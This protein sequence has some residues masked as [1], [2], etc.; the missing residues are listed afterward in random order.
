MF[1]PFSMVTIFFLKG[2]IIGFII[3]V[4]VGP[5]GVVCARRMLMFGRR[6]GFFSGM[7]SA[8]AD[9]IYGFVAA[10]GL[11]LVSD[12]LVGHN[13]F[14][15]LV[16]GTLLCFLGVKALV[17]DP[18]LN[19]D[20]PNSLKKY[21]GLY[22]STFFLALTNPLT[23]FSFAAIFAGF[24]LAGIKGSV[25]S[26]GVLVLGFFL[27]STLWWLLLVGIFSIFYKRFHLDQL[28]WVNRISGG[29]IIA[30]G[31]LVLLSLEW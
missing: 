3:A 9:A 10:F 18:S 12:F 28:R 11:T 30:S 8:T 31:I 29:I 24:G 23:I 1:P 13:V 6:A 27:G 19:R 20:Y 4:P 14:L 2:L 17:A 21:A 16:G 25:Y 5:I 15:R 22:S 7:G 26:T